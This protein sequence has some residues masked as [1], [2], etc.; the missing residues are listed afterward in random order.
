MMIRDLFWPR[1]RC[2][3]AGGFGLIGAALVRRLHILGA[4]VSVI[5]AQIVKSGAN[6]TQLHDLESAVA[7]T[8]ADV[9]DRTQLARLLPGQ[10]VIFNVLG[11]PGHLE[12]LQNAADDLAA[13][14]LAP[15]ALLN[16]YV[17]L[18][19]SAAMVFTSTRQVYGRPHYLPVDE[20]HRLDPLDLNAVHRLM[21]EMYHRRFAE[22]RNLPIRILR[23]G[24]T[25]GPGMRRFDGRQ[26]FIGAWIAA[27]ERDE[28]FEVWGGEQ[29][30]ELLDVEDAVD[31][32]L[33]AA[34]AAVP[35]GAVY[36][37]A[38]DTPITLKNLAAQ[39]I[40]IYGSGR[41]ECRD[42]PADSAHIEIG[43]FR[44]SIARAHAELGW[45]PRTGLRMTLQR[46]LLGANGSNERF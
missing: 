2:L 36:N 28:V 10:Q 46:A 23:L 18:C 9:A 5:D 19:P 30:R 6:R 20:A 21:A 24:N 16:G 34:S 25:I 7:I 44:T 14:A 33:L 22:Q 31:A 43:S 42:M 15:I 38:G 32:L 13:N 35:N 45:Q 41:F 39:V 3:V 17:E 40:E 8:V 29:E 26:S 11:M 12:S 37:I 4:Q 27:L 1:R